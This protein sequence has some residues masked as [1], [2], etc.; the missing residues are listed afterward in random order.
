MNIK[1][2]P[3]GYRIVINHRLIITEGMLKWS[4]R[5]WKWYRLSRGRC[6]NKM[7]NGCYYAIKTIPCPEYMKEINNGK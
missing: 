7:I 1:P 3:K 4:P 5:L 6:E 2:P